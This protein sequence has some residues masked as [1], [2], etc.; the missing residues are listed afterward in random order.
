M[1]GPP[2]P[3]IVVPT[4]AKDHHNTSHRQGMEAAH[5]LVDEYEAQTYAKQST[6]MVKTSACA[7]G[8]PSEVYDWVLYLLETDVSPDVVHKHLLT[9][10]H[11]KSVPPSKSRASEEL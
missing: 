5:I 3:D 6:E 9:P 8:G 11:T 10:E 4:Y 7:I 1:Y 2:P